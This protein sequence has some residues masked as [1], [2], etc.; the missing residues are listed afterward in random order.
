MVLFGWVAGDEEREGEGGEAER[1]EGEP[2]ELGEFVGGVTDA[3]EDLIH[4]ADEFE[5]GE[6]GQA[7]E[8]EGE[9]GEVPEAD[10]SEDSD[11]LGAEGGEEQEREGGEEGGAAEDAAEAEEHGGDTDRGG[12]GLEVISALAG[13]RLVELGDG[14]GFGF[15]RGEFESDIGILAEETERAIAFKADEDVVTAAAVGIG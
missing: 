15:A 10:R 8:V 6:V 7:G 11:E 14:G 2:G 12:G 3:A 4:G 5:V 1:D 9:V 13:E